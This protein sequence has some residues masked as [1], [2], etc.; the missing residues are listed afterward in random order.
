MAKNLK[1]NIKNAQ[2]AEAL[3]LNQIKQPASKKSKEE[4]EP[5]EQ[6]KVEKAAAEPVV[7]PSPVQPSPVAES[8]PSQHSA[9][10]PERTFERK[11]E[12]NQSS[13][14]PYGERREGERREP[15]SDNR[16]P[17]S[18]PPY[19]KSS[20]PRFEGDRPQGDRPPRPYQD[21]PSRPPFDRSQGQDRPSY[22]DRDGQNR[23][24]GQDRPSYGD[25]GPQQRPPYGDRGPQQ[26]PPY[27]D[28]GQ[29]QRPPYGDRGPQ[30]RPYQQNASGGAQRPYRSSDQQGYTP[31]P[32]PGG[33]R[34]PFRRDT[35]PPIDVK[36]AFP[37][38]K[39][40]PTREAPPAKKTRPEDESFARK[41]PASKDAKDVRPA[42]KTDAHRSFDARDRLGLRT[43]DEEIWRKKK[44]FK[45]KHVSQEEVIRP[46]ELHIRIPISVKDL[47]NEMKLKASQL[48]S[49]LFMQGVPLTLN[50]LL[51][52]I[53]SYGWELVG[54]QGNGY[55]FKRELV[56]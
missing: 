49:K 32:H 28:R 6:P 15:R 26:R 9:P 20:Q 27:G 42:K 21:R 47:A 3:K 25:R 14:P 16:Y 37:T 23:F 8:P 45:S 53:G 39:D 44:A 36:K 11:A 54:F 55:I 41:S 34:P 12:F 43:S 10:A 46:K 38:V 29:Q 4:A 19:H 13:R 17:S 5:V 30:N 22:G 18:R 24:Q 56:D 2:L 52:D 51:D 35:A 1:L 48:I 33:P 50:D 31:R 40:H 7:E